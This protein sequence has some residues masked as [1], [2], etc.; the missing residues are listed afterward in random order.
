MGRDRTG[1]GEER[2]AENISAQSQ[3][4]TDAPAL[5]EE[6]V[7]LRDLVLALVTPSCRRLEVAVVALRARSRPSA[8]GWH[9]RKPQQTRKHGL[10]LTMLPPEEDESSRYEP[11]NA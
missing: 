11:S 4:D 1:E 3:V 6:T 5:R 10:T 7:A 9:H 2:Q 8:L